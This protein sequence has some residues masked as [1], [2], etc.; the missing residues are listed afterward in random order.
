MKCCSLGLLVQH[1]QA[2]EF[3]DSL[4]ANRNPKRAGC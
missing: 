2:Y 1:Y 3:E 4:S